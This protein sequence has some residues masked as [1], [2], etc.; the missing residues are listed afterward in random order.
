MLVEKDQ[1]HNVNFNFD[2]VLADMVYIFDFALTVFSLAQTLSMLAKIT[3]S[4]TSATPLQL[5]VLQF[6]K[7]L[8][9]SDCSIDSK[10]RNYYLKKTNAILVSKTLNT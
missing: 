3:M 8:E 5:M 6:H 1:D 10:L 9:R 7:Y 4:I 2:C